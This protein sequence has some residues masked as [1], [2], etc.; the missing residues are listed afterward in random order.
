MLD[1]LSELT[2]STEDT[3]QGKFLTF[4]IGKEYYGLEIK[5]VTEIIGLQEI[6][7]IPQMPLYIKGIINLRGKIIPVVD[8]RLRF[9][10]EPRD[11]N[12]RTCIIVI[13]IQ[14][15]SIG[16]IVDHV[17]EVIVIAAENI[18]PPPDSKIGFHNRYVKGIGKIENEVK[19][20][21]DCDRLL[22]EDEIDEIAEAVG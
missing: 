22:N 7:E 11:Y 13:E 17:A 18:V 14:D 8:V 3:Q 4:S 5:Y 19:L 1:V 6:T 10:K 16:L 2:E 9:K 20:L 12:E 15:I 21:L